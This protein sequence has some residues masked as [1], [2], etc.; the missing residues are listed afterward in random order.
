MYIFTN[1]FLEGA[2]YN[3]FSQYTLFIFFLWYLADITRK[4]EKEKKWKWNIWTQKQAFCF[5][6]HPTVCR[7]GIAQNKAPYNTKFQLVLHNIQCSP[8]EPAM[9]YDWLWLVTTCTLYWIWWTLVEALTYHVGV[10]LTI[11]LCNNTL[12]SNHLASFTPIWSDHSHNGMPLASMFAFIMT[13][14]KWIDAYTHTSLLQQLEWGYYFMT[15]VL[16]V[17]VNIRTK[18]LHCFQKHDRNSGCN[19][20][21]WVCSKF[22]VKVCFILMCTRFPELIKSAGSHGNSVTTIHDKGDDYLTLLWVTL[23]RLCKPENPL[24]DTAQEW[25]TKWDFHQRKDLFQRYSCR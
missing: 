20:V 9:K 8:K 3:H 2:S 1:F 14:L 15:V 6:E 23:I 19:F 4:N 5:L 12:F 24:S 7:G 22:L 18:F 10:G 13:N 11:Q 21:S 25:D 17:S 16:W